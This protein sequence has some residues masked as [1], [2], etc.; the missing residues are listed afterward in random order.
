MTKKIW[1]VIPVYTCRL[2]G[3][4]IGKAKIVYSEKEASKD[5]FPKEYKSYW[6]EDDYDTYTISYVLVQEHEVTF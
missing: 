3:E 5:I 6:G 2:N 4:T 1:V